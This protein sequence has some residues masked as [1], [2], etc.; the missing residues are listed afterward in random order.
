MTYAADIILRNISFLA[1]QNNSIII[2]I[3]RHA[4]SM[5]GVHF[6]C[7]IA[8][9]T[10]FSL[11]ALFYL[12]IPLQFYLQ[13]RLVHLRSDFFRLQQLQSPHLVHPLGVNFSPPCMALESAPHGNLR[14]L[15]KDS[16][17]ASIGRNTIHLIALQVCKY[18]HY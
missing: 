12:S 5:L 6:P 18:V 11:S 3:D 9:L 4:C 10:P 7:I 16:R 8:V 17:G 1:C 15:L 14:Q 13:S 2:Y